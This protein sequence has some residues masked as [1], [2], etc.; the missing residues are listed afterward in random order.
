M[1]LCPI[2][3]QRNFLKKVSLVSSKTFDGGKN[4]FAAKLEQ[5]APAKPVFQGSMGA[6][7]HI[8]TAKRRFCGV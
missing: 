4:T 6:N 7:T 3:Y 5:N 1:G 8:F 2:P